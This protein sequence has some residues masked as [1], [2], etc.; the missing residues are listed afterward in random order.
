MVFDDKTLAPYRG[1]EPYIFLSYSHRNSDQASQIIR[2]LNQLRFRVWY[3][4]GLI[5]GREWDESIAR[6]I[7]GCSYFV[8]LI[9]KEYLASANCRDELNYARD[10]NKP[11]L[12]I[13]LEEVSLPAGMELRLGR[14]FAIHCDRYPDES[15]FYTRFFD[16]EGIERCCSSVPPEIVQRKAKLAAQAK[17]QAESASRNQTNAFSHD[18]IEESEPEYEPERHRSGLPVFGVFLLFVL[19][20]AAFILLYYLVPLGTPAPPPTP[21]PVVTSTPVPSAQIDFEPSPSP[22]VTELPVVTDTPEVTPT[23]TP[24]PETTLTPTLPPEPTSD[25]I[26]ETDPTPTPTLPPEPEIDLT[27]PDDMNTDTEPDDMN[28]V[29]ING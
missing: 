9:S 1:K 19:V 6:V 29:I 24:T 22:V 10:K 8:A 13:Y 5:P 2:R 12:L 7:M 26:I 16:A 28:I 4:E 17:A 11:L 25:L 15:A 20:A 27:T 21:T 3:D 14:L 23:P 18:P